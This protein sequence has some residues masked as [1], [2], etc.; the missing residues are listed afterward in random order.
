VDEDLCVG[1]L[2]CAEDCPYDAIAMIPRAGQPAGLSELVA[3]VDPTLCVSCG[4]C[5]GSC[6]PMGVGPPGRTGRDQMTDV[7]AFVAAPERRAGEI[8]VIGCMHGAAAWAVDVAALGGALYEVTCAGNLH[9]S[10]I[11][12]LLRRGAGGVLVAGCPPRDCWHR[13]GPRWLNERV[14]HGREAELQARVDRARV[15]IVGVNS[16]ERTQAIDALRRFAA[17]VHGLAPTAEDIPAIETTCEPSLAG[18]ES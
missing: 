11:E 8:I 4:I 2:Q 6:A 10:V 12:L 16:R 18:R 1:C 13:E 15:R 5:A 3:R 7:R 17:D 9:T 14:H